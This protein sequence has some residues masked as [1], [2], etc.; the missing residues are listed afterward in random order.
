MTENDLE[1]I[2]AHVR[3]YLPAG[4]ATEGSAWF[5]HCI[6]QNIQRF[7]LAKAKEP[8]LTLDEYLRASGKPPP[9]R[10]R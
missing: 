2:K 8:A 3:S 5:E 7:D 9:K 4:L 10:G 6:R 1:K